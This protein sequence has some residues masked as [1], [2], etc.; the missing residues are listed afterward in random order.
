MTSGIIDRFIS[1]GLFWYRTPYK[2]INDYTYDDYTYD[3][4]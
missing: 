3:D 4:L 2:F 1:K